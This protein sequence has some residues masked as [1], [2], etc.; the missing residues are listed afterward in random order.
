MTVKLKRLYGQLRSIHAKVA[1][2][3]HDFY[4][5]LSGWLV[6][7]FAFLATEDLAVKNMS[8]PPKAKPDPDKPGKLVPNGAA[9]KAGL[10]RTILDGAP[11][12]LLGMLRTKAAEAASVFALANTREVKPTQRFY[13]RNGGVKKTLKDRVHSCTSAVAIGGRDENA[14][15]T[16]LRWLLED[17]FWSGIGQ[18]GKGCCQKLH[19]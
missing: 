17:D 14:A 19:L 10:N 16:L 2:Q 12:M 15:K 5:K 11:S 13:R 6:S 4:H 8:R 3:R 18:A 9:A 1:R 7:R